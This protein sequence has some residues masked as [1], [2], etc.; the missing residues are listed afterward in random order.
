MITRIPN[1]LNFYKKWAGNWI[2]AQYTTGEFPNTATSSYSAGGG[3][4]YRMK[5]GS[6][7]TDT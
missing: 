3:P 7:M 5:Y 2:S 1:L 6:P 4:D